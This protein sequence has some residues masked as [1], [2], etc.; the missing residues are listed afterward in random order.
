MPTADCKYASASIIEFCV[1]LL[2]KTASRPI[3]PFTGT[4]RILS[5]IPLLAL[6]IVLCE[7]SRP[8]KDIVQRLC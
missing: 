2:S 4:M 1:V 6:A 3:M 8:F 7:S 5:R